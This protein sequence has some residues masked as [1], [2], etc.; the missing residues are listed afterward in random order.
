VASGSEYLVWKLLDSNIACLFWKRWSMHT[1]LS[2]VAAAHHTTLPVISDL[3]I[4]FNLFS[5][6]II[7]PSDL[8]KLCSS[9]ISKRTRQLSCSASHLCHLIHIVSLLL[10]LN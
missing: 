6:V 1:T 2:L 9:G 10:L 8:Y 7:V 5:T 3:Q 4:V